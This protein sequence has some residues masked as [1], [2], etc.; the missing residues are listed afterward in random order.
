MGEARTGGHPQL[1]TR[2][3]RL[4]LQLRGPFLGRGRAG[5]DEPGLALL[6]SS[7]TPGHVFGAVMSEQRVRDAGPHRSVLTCFTPARPTDLWLC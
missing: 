5:P 2:G 7:Y 1:S 4:A 3:S 6:V